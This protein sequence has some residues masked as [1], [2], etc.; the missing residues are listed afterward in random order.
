[1]N[2]GFIPI[3]FIVVGAVVV[4]SA[5][6]GAIKYKDEL[7][8][9]PAAVMNIF[10]GSDEE[11]AQISQDVSVFEEIEADKEESKG[12]AKG[13][14]REDKA[15][16]KEEKKQEKKGPRI[17]KGPKTG[18][19]EKKP[20]EKIEEIQE[21]E[22]EMIEAEP[23][24][25]SNINVDINKIPTDPVVIT[26]ITN[27]ESNTSLEYGLSPGSYDWSIYNSISKETNAG[28]L[29]A[30]YLYVEFNRVHHYRVSSVD[31]DGN[32]VESENMTFTKF[33]YPFS[34]QSQRDSE[35]PTATIWITDQVG[36]DFT[37]VWS[38]S[39]SGCL[40]DVRNQPATGSWEDWEIGTSSTSKPYTAS[41]KGN[42]KF[43]ARATDP[44]G[45]TGEWS[46]KVEVKIK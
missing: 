19:K 1:M 28:F 22:I 39:E 36:N 18:P 30:I 35:A 6:F 2:K 3:I 45:N 9:V 15:I 41:G 43:K 26:W 25:I 10:M 33:Y 24:T 29:H 46:E 44:A 16:E 12:I 27:K 40:F 23:L 31:S 7:S 32:K 11:S 4:A 37:V 5:A 42:Y 21:Q 34:I 38:S 13:D 20:E 8:Q 14:Q 17:V